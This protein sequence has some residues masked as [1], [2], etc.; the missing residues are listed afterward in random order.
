MA[1][2]PVAVSV[3]CPA[4]TDREVGSRRRSRLVKQQERPRNQHGSHGGILDA[5]LA[6]S[7]LFGAWVVGAVLLVGCSGGGG[8]L[9][10]VARDVGSCPS[11]PPTAPL[12]KLNAGGQGLAK[13]LVPIK[14]AKVRGCEYD[15]TTGRNGTF[16]LEQRSAAEFEA[17]TNRLPAGSLAVS[18]MPSAPSVWL[19]FASDSERVDVVEYCGE[20][21]NGLFAAVPT[22]HWLNQIH[23]LTTAARR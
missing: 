19:T 7:R 4:R 15:P 20:T 1:T 3:N 17:E 22:S 10:N 8:T 21:T 5:M 9:S 12:T 6:K 13:M 16:T 14:A 11:L 18:C 2:A 23:Q